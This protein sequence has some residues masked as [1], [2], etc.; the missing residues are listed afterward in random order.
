MSTPFPLGRK[1]E[2]DP[3]SRRFAFVPRT[4]QQVV[5]KTWRRYGAVL[6]QGSLGSCTGNA[7]TH[8]L[9]SLPLHLKKSQIWDQSMAVM[10]YSAATGL[11]PW[12]GSYPP[13]D[14]GSSG[15]AVCKAAVQMGHINSYKWAFGFDHVLSTLMAGPVLVGTYWYSGMSYPDANGFV[16]PSGSKEGGHEYLLVGVN[17]SKRY[18]TFQNSWSSLWGVRGRFYMTFD[19]FKRLLDEDGDAVLP[20]RS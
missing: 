1:I 19:N 17:T 3:A 4:S 6:D 14:T 2:H 7:M 5:T 18:L 11:D 9:N 12:E 16:T 10:L 8:A 15:L 13:E 20:V